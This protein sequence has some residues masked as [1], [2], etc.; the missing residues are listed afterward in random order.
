MPAGGAMQAAESGDAVSQYVLGACFKAGRGVSV[1]Y[2]KVRL[3]SE[4]TCSGGVLCIYVRALSGVLKGTVSSAA[5][6]AY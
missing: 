1:N 6:C 2:P 4:T 5:W 3:F